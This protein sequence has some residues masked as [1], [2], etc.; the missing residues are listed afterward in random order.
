MLLCVVNVEVY[1]QADPT[2]PLLALHSILGHSNT[3][4]Q[5]CCGC[6]GSLS[7]AALFCMD[8]GNHH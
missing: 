6:A 4:A 5:T 8:I 2:W 7:T 1:K 3:V